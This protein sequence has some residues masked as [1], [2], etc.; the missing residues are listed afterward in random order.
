M[1]PGTRANDSYKRKENKKS[2]GNSVELSL[3]VAGTSRDLSNIV[4]IQT[5]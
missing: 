2:G 4:T 5:I 3:S 1:N